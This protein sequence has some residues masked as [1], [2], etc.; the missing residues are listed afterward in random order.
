MGTGNSTCPYVHEDVRA[1]LSTSFDNGVLTLKY[2]NAIGERRQRKRRYCG[3]RLDV[4]RIDYHE[5]TT[6][7]RADERHS[8]PRYA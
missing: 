1:M 6:K 7:A 8:L 4:R 2:E 3:S 5:K